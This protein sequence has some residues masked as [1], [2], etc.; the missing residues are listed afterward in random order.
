MHTK[1]N[2]VQKLAIN[3][4]VEFEQNWRKTPVCCLVCAI[5]A[6]SAFVYRPNYILIYLALKR[7]ALMYNL[8]TYN[9]SIY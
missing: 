1:Q 3:A 8:N 2:A 6:C 9:Y 4:E 7:K 5:C